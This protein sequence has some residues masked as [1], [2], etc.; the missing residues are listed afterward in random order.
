MNIA[1]FWDQVLHGLLPSG[2]FSLHLHH[3]FLCALII[4]L[5]SFESSPISDSYLGI[6]FVSFHITTLFVHNLWVYSEAEEAVLRG[7]NGPESTGF[8]MRIRSVWP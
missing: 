5:L 1:R 4:P 2:A 7:A 8:L 3:V 6:T